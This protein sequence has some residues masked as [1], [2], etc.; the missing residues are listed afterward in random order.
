MRTEEIKPGLVVEPGG[1]DLTVD[2]GSTFHEPGASIRLDWREAT[3]LAETVLEWLEHVGHPF[4]A[5]A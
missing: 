2:I 5:R 3:L 4:E 1:S